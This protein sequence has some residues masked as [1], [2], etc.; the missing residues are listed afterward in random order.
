MVAVV[1]E[2]RSRRLLVTRRPQGR[3][4]V[5]Y[6]ECILL[7]D[8]EEPPFLRLSCVLP[9]GLCGVYGALDAGIEAYTELGI[10]TCGLGLSSCNLEDTFI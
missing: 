2:L 4:M 7:I 9:Q 3:D 6:V 5:T 8:K 1:T 10:P